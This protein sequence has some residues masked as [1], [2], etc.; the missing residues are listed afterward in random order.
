MINVQIEG[1]SLLVITG[2]NLYRGALTSQTMRQRTSNYQNGRTRRPW[3]D[4]FDFHLGGGKRERKR[5]TS[6]KR[7]FD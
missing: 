3:P 4:S 1:F 5:K 6:E 7:S 2:I